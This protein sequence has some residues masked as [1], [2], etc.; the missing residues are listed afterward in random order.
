MARS[1]KSN[2]LIL[3]L[4]GLILAPLLTGCMNVKVDLKIDQAARATGTYNIEFD[5]EAAESFEIT[6]KEEMFGVLTEKNSGLKKGDV[7]LSESDKNYIADIYVKSTPLDDKDMLAEVLPNG[8]IKFRYYAEPSSNSES[9]LE[10][11]ESFGWTPEMMGTYV[12]V[13]EMPGKIKSI[14][15]S[16]TKLSDTKFK[17][18]HLVSDGANIEVVSSVDKS[19]VK[20]LMEV[21][22]KPSVTCIKGK[23]TKKFDGNKCPAGFKLKK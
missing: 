3:L 22:K 23:V 15:A 14:S 11:M 4:S 6:S 18:S 8:D 2:R 21:V 9:D 1:L 19:I 5:K 12:V 13:I 7:K 20:K 16:A 17:I 10:M